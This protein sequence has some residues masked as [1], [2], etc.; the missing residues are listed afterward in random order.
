VIEGTGAFNIAYGRWHHGRFARQPC[1]A[2]LHGS[3]ARLAVI[4]KKKMFLPVQ[5]ALQ[6]QTSFFSDVLLFRNVT[7]KWITQMRFKRILVH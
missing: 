3:F 4:C 5:N 6:K 7:W 1:M 2:A